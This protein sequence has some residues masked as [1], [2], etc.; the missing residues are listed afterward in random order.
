MRCIKNKEGA[1]SENALQSGKCRCTQR[2]KQAVF[3]NAD[4]KATMSLE[5]K[6]T[7]ASAIGKLIKISLKKGK[8][9]VTPQKAIQYSVNNNGPG[10]HKS[11]KSCEVCMK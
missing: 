5:G 3:K 10:P 4:V 7:V 6:T 1:V 9:F 8:M 11:F 2:T